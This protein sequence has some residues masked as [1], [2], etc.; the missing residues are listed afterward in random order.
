MTLDISS[1]CPA[2]S[3]SDATFVDSSMANVNLLYNSVKY[4][5]FVI[6]DTGD[7]L[8][9]SFD[10]NNFTGPI[11]TLSNH[12]PGGLADGLDIEGIGTVKWKFRT[13]TAVVVVT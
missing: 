3:T 2:L 7:S 13:N 5:F 12:R 8:D 9:T 4:S 11:T 10:K 6:F 1:S